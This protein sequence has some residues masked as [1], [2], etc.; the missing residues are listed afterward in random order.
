MIETF[1]WDGFVD[2]QIDKCALS[3]VPVI[4][5]ID[6]EEKSGFIRGVGGGLSR[7]S[8]DLHSH[9]WG[10][11][12]LLCWSSWRTWPENLGSPE[13]FLIGHIRIFFMRRF[14]SMG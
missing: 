10:W 14:I 1:E 3:E 9:G 13:C 12:F 6:I 5:D 7:T 8:S 11:L 2:D 4:D